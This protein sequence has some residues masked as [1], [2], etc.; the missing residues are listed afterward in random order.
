MKEHFFKPQNEAAEIKKMSEKEPNFI[1]TRLLKALSGLKQ[2]TVTGEIVEEGAYI[3]G[4]DDRKKGEGI[5][6]HVLL[7]SRVAYYL[8]KSLQERAPDKYSQL[9]LR[10]VVEGAILHDI[11]KLYG[12][13]RERLPAEIK[14][15]LEFIKASCR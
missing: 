2:V 13:D 7:T 3:W 5:F 9:N 10:S 11:T 1:S 12:E 6:N 4:V 14:K 15:D 8:A